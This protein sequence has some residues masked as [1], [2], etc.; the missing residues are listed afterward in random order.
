MLNAQLALGHYA[1]PVVQRA[2]KLAKYSGVQEL[3]VTL[4]VRLG[5]AWRTAGLRGGATLV[6]IPLH[7]SR[8]RAR[9]FNQAERLAK[10]V[11][12]AT[13]LS[14]SSC[15]TRSRRTHPQSKF[16]EDEHRAANVEGAFVVLGVAPSRVLLVDDIATSGATLETAASVLKAAGSL[17][18]ESAV[19]AAER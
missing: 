16:S 7:W 15:L 11:A 5:S 13:G 12:L 3:A 2:V 17:W 6:S 18:V 9:G 1:D 8:E 14:F 4:G 19:V 10:G